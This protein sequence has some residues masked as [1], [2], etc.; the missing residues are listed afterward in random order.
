MSQ[1]GAAN[2]KSLL[3]YKKYF[4]IPRLEMVLA[5]GETGGLLALLTLP[6]K[7]E[8]ASLSYYKAF[9]DH[10]ATAPYLSDA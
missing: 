4:F 6:S 1:E 7:P 3:S 2:N 8:L 9:L 5:P 10:S